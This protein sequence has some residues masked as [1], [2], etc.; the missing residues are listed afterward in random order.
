MAIPSQRSCG[1]AIE[2]AMRG[3]RLHWWPRWPTVG[4]ACARAKNRTVNAGLFLA[5][6]V[7]SC[8]LHMRDV[9]M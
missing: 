4:R 2:R 5:Y 3:A 6:S 7:G 1:S 9:T 8:D